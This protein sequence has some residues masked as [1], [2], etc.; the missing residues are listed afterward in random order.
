MSRTACG[1]TI[2]FSSNAL[3]ANS[4]VTRDCWSS[5]TPRPTIMSPTR[6]TW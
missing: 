6:R 3:A 5:Q 4:E 2:L 1:G